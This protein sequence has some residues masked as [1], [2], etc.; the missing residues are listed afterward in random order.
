MRK[1]EV[2][3]NEE[4]DNHIYTETVNQEYEFAKPFDIIKNQGYELA[5]PFDNSEGSNGD[6]SRNDY[7]FAAVIKDDDYIYTDTKEGEYDT[8]Q[9][10]EKRKIR[11]DE[12]NLYSHTTAGLATDNDY[13]TTYGTKVN[14]TGDIYDH[15]TV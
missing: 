9:N 12:G 5:Q 3:N 13:D 11:V 10:K 1:A 2:K 6:P 8:F 14:D 7:E 15:T 4:T